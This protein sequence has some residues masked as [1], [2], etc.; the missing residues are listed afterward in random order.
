MI[1]TNANVINLFRSSRKTDVVYKEYAEE[2][3]ENFYTLQITPA[4]CNDNRTL[5]LS[6]KLYFRFGSMQDISSM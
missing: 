4:L 1:C 2:L 6:A 5:L 3:H